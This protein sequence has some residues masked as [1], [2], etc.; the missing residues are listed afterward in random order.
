MRRISLGLCAVVALAWWSLPPAPLRLMRL[1]IAVEVPLRAPNVPVDGPRLTHV[2]PDLP[3]PPRAPP[4]R[5]ARE[6]PP[7]TPPPPQSPPPAMW[8]PTPEAM[9]DAPS[10]VEIAPWHAGLLDPPESPAPTSPPARHY[11][12]DMATA[13]LE[14]GVLE[15]DAAMGLAFIGTA[16]VA[17]AVESAVRAYAPP[18]SHARLRAHVG[19][20]GRV[21]SVRVL[22]Y[23]DGSESAWRRAAAHASRSLADDRFRMRSA[24]RRGANVTVEVTSNLE[25]PSGN[26]REHEM[27]SKRR[28]E[29]PRWPYAPAP[30][31]RLSWREE[32]SWTPLPP[33]TERIAAPPETTFPPCDPG[34]PSCPGSRFDL[35]DIGAKHIR[36]VRSRAEVAPAVPPPGP[37][38]AVGDCP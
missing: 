3:A 38:R 2:V 22:S 4:R 30:G 16:A 21:S 20:D 31:P 32:G 24:L 6:G 12:P 34:E 17:A 28:F 23:R 35:A 25:L 29:K 26:G 8:P 11:D 1:E 33:D 19:S 14:R 37:R 10:A 18:V 9:P 27:S 5:P 13:L 36:Q 7:I 15:R